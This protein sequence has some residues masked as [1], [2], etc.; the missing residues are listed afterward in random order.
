MHTEVAL[1]RYGP[2]RGTTTNPKVVT[3]GVVDQG[4]KECVCDAGPT[5][6]GLPIRAPTR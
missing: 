1:L 3:P 5:V 6:L 2:K 4:G